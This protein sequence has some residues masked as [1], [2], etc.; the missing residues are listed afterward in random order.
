MPIYLC[1]RY[2]ISYEERAQ[3]LSESEAALLAYRRMN[4]EERRLLSNATLLA[5]KTEG[6]FTDRSYVL[7]CCLTLRCNIAEEIPFTLANH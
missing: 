2:A 7:T 6:A 1:E 3:T 5:R 4:A